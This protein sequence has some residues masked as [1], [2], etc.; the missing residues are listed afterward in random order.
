MAKQAQKL[1]RE[2]GRSGHHLRRSVDPLR[3][4]IFGKVVFLL[5]REA[6]GFGARG[7]ENAA[8]G[9]DG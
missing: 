5:W 4:R 8:A 3:T 9:V 6:D 7:R 2:S 1:F